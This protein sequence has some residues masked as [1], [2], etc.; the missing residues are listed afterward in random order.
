MTGQRRV[1]ILGAAGRDFHDFNVLYRGDAGAA[2]LRITN[3]RLHVG[4]LD[5]PGYGIAFDPD[6]PA[7]I[8]LD[9][10][11]RESEP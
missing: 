3:G 2:W 4:S 11:R 9:V 1:V 7:M 6:L 10:W 5:A 8:P